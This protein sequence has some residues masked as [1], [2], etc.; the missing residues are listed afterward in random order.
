MDEREYQIQRITEL[1]EEEL[2]EIQKL[3]KEKYTTPSGAGAQDTLSKS[4]R[5]QRQGDELSQRVQN[6]LNMSGSKPKF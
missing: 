3:I 5:L 2:A 4:D 1:K 6:H